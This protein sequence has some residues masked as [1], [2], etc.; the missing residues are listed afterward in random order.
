MN[1]QYYRFSH[2][3]PTGHDVTTL[4]KVMR[5][6]DIAVYSLAL[7]PNPPRIHDRIL[8]DEFERMAR[9]VFVPSS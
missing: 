1:E 7:I 6:A 4:A 8:K 2:Q 9:S 3:D 5:N